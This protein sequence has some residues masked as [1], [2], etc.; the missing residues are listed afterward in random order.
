MIALLWVVLAALASHL[1]SRCQLEV[2]DVTLRH[3]VVVLRRQ[4]HGQVRLANLD[5]LVLA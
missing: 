1:K 4:M 5:R 3:Q 2:Q